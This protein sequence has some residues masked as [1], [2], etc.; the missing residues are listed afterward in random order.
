MIFS[1][2]DLMLGSIFS[3]PEYFTHFRVPQGSKG[4]TI[5]E[6]CHT[7]KYFRKIAINTEQNELQSPFCSHFV[8]FSVPVPT[9][10]I[11]KKKSNV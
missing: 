10:G 1:M 2:K 7:S 8:T 4:N 3:I 5:F 6:I 11:F 9:M